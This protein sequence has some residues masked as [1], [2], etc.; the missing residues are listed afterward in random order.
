M[1]IFAKAKQLNNGYFLLPYALMGK[2]PEEVSKKANKKVSK[3]VNV[4]F[5]VASN[6][7]VQTDNGYKTFMPKDKTRFTSSARTLL[8]KIHTEEKIF[9]QKAE[10]PYRKITEKLGHSS[11]T[12]ASNFKELKKV[13]EKPVKSTYHISAEYDGKPFILCYEFL[14]TEELQLD[15]GQAPVQLTDLEAQFVSMVVNNKLNPKKSEDFVASVGNVEKALNIPHS[16]AQAL[17]DRLIRKGVC[18]CYKRY[19][20]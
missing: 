17:I 7:N 20:D 10:L 12:T 18:T 5:V 11:K 1:S 19:T 8:G 9:A 13:L 14:F 16:T 15:E 2:A 4:L 3:A 6:D